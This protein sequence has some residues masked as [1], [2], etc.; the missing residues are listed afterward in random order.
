MRIVRWFLCS[1]SR[2][3]GR[4]NLPSRQSQGPRSAPAML[5]TRRRQADPGSSRAVPLP[6]RGARVEHELPQRR[7]RK[8][9]RA[10]ARALRSRSRD[11]RNARALPLRTTEP[12]FVR[13][14]RGS[15]RLPDRGEHAN[16]TFGRADR[17]AGGEAE[18]IADAGAIASS[19]GLAK[20]K[21]IRTFRPC[22]IG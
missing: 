20:G 13:A 1:R 14:R 16:G 19:H 18:E 11:Q 12:A 6:A 7:R 4:R 21:S 2:S 15:D 22:S 10:S 3:L 5:E 8:R 17:D 9:S